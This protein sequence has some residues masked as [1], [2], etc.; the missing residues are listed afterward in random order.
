VGS[1]GEAKGRRV[2][3]PNLSEVCRAPF[4]K[5]IVQGKED[6]HPSIPRGRL[7]GGGTVKRWSMSRKS[8]V[9]RRWLIASIQEN[10][11]AHGMLRAGEES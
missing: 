7:R 4:W 11:E 1:G 3:M 6:S 8:L 10:D 2:K 9:M 5:K